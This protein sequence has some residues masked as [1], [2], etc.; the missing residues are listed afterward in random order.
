ME[1]ESI[2]ATSSSLVIAYH[3]RKTDQVLF[4]RIAKQRELAQMSHLEL[5][6]LPNR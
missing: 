4:L 2:P 6:F 5:T 1:T 3:P